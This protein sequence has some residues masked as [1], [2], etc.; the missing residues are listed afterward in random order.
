MPLTPRGGRFSV[1]AAVSAVLA[2]VMAVVYVSVMH[3]Q[4]DDPLAWVMAVL[5]VAAALAGSG[6]FG[7]ASYRRTALVASGVLLVG[8]GVLA[9]LSIGFPIL[10]AGVLALVAAATSAPRPAPQPV[11]SA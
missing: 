4:D 11:S 3:S 2:V 7:G 9:I 10:I 8:L 5:I 6:A 1:L